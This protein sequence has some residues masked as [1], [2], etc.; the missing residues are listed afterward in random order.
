MEVAG[1]KVERTDGTEAFVKLL[2]EQ[3]HSARVLNAITDEFDGKYD[4]VFA[5]AV[6]LHF[7]PSETANVFKKACNSVK[8]N[9]ILA[10]T[11]KQGDGEEWSEAK[12]DAPR[13]FC[14]GKSQHYA[15][16]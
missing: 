12:L 9:G 15:K 11:V 16:R 10:F 3:G 2:Q 14:Y 4:M 5:N 6:L 7:T 8:Q 1:Y 13:Y